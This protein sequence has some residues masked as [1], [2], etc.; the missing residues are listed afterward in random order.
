MNEEKKQLDSGSLFCG[1]L[2]IVIGSM[3]MLD[4]MGYA[5]L[6]D[7]LHNYWP[8]FLVAFGISRFLRRRHAWSGVSLIVI[9]LWLQATTLHWWDLTFDSSWPLLLIGFGA[10]MVARTLT[11]VLRGD[12]SEARHDQ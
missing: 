6:H 5:D 9:G 1:V 4:R 12:S 11:G 2:L 3:F 10:V 8:M 7:V